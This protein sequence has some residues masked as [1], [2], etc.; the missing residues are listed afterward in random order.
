MFILSQ[1]Y[2]KKW[3][4]GSSSDGIKYIYREVKRNNY[5]QFWILIVSM[6]FF[7]I[8]SDE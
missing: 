3:K 5:N 8:K 6:E 2:N 7:F 4:Y 1:V